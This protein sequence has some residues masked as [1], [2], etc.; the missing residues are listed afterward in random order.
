[1][2]NTNWQFV[3]RGRGSFSQEASY[4]YVGEGSGE[5]QKEPVIAYRITSLKPECKALLASVCLVMAVSFGVLLERSLNAPRSLAA[6][7]RIASATEV[8]KRTTDTPVVSTTEGFDC[9]NG[10]STWGVSW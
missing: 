6:P 4:D 2:V 9:R 7:P 5:F 10:Y 3:G 8:A 1:M